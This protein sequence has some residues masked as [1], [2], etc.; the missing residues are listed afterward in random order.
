ML[1]RLGHSQSKSTS[2]SVAKLVRVNFGR[3]IRHPGDMYDTVARVE[4]L[5]SEPTAWVCESLSKT[6][7][8]HSVLQTGIW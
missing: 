3:V 4:L 1:D 2:F 8:V 6:R 5:D 7:R